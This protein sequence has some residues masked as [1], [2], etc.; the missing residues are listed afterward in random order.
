MGTIERGAA[1]R[2]CWSVEG[3]IVAG[4]DEDTFTL[5]ATAVERVLSGPASLPI[6]AAVHLVGE[7]PEM[8]S[9]GFPALVGSPIKVV[10]HAEG[11]AGLAE[12]LS[13]ASSAADA[14]E[15]ALVVAADLPER[16]DSPRSLEGALAIALV[17]GTDTGSPS[18]ELKGGETRRATEA[19][20][21]LREADCMA[22]PGRWV[23]AWSRNSVLGSPID[24]R[25]L[26]EAASATVHT[27]SQGAYVPRPRYLENLPSRWRLVAER[28]LTCSATTFPPR[29]V[30]GHCGRHEPL[31]RLPL[32]LEGA[33]VVA[34]TVIGPGGQ[35]T[36][37]D[38]EV[39]ALGSYGVVLAEL[40]V[41]V[42]A[43]FL[44]TD[45]PVRRLSVGSAIGTRLRR[46]YPM[47]GEWRYGRKAVALATPAH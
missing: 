20:L 27:V 1:Y 43:T 30:C 34:A 23:G 35:P 45:A 37:F 3:K 6:P 28:C 25:R 5:A 10:R 7:Y 36:E 44:V 29:G 38:A 9:W 11:A 47:E 17:V 19:A 22:P 42:R 15:R 2:P 40:A 24:E 4:P 13:A 32:P 21:G 14:G 39:E 8:A 12:A 31:A 46:L 33:T 18:P 41:G 16:S 26:R